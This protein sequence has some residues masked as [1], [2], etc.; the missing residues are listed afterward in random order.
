MGRHTP[1]RRQGVRDRRF[2]RLVIATR[3][4]QPNS[5][6]GDYCRRRVSLCALFARVLQTPGATEPIMSSAG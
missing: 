4:R 3:E 1:V 6:I 2:A 5:R